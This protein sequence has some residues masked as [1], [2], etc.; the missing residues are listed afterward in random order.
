MFLAVIAVATYSLA[1]L[2][3]TSGARLLLDSF[4]AHQSQDRLIRQSHLNLDF[5]TSDSSERSEDTSVA[6]VEL[7]T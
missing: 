6:S 1:M 2:V 3:R 5:E 7:A 4:V